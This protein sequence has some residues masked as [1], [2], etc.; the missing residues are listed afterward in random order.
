MVRRPETRGR[1]KAGEEERKI[2]GMRNAE[3]GEKTRE[4]A[5]GGRGRQ[6]RPEN[7]GTT[8]RKKRKSKGQMSEEGQDQRRDKLQGERRK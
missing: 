3:T 5:T 1:E 8:R 6:T 2:R 4:A 7:K